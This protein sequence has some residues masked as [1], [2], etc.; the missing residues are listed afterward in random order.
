[1]RLAMYLVVTLYVQLNLLASEGPYSMK[2]VNRDSG[3]VSCQIR[4]QFKPGNNFQYGTGFED[5]ILDQ[6]LAKRLGMVVGDERA[7]AR[8]WLGSKSNEGQD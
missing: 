3:R 5:N 2:S 4:W 1:V 7:V 8:E 6:H